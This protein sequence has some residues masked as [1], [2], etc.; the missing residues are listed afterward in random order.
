MKKIE[1]IIK[2]FKLDDVK[3]AL[4]ELGVVGMTVTEVRGLW[5]QIL[6][7]APATCRFVFASRVK[8]RL[9]F[10]RFKTHGGYA[11]LRTDALRFTEP[12]IDDLVAFLFALTSDDF[13][14]LEKKEL[15]AQRARKNKRPERDTAVALGKK[16]NLGDLAPNPDLKNPADLGLYG[17]V[18][19]PEK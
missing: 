5:N 2:P 9:Q 6:R 3:E 13:A 18:A 16:G 4:T 14:A 17:P 7:D 8:P 12:E 19:A 10:A 11:E 15:A 1:A